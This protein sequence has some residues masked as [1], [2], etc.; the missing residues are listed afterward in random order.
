MVRPRVA[1]MIHW[2]RSRSLPVSLA[3]AAG[4][5]VVLLYWMWRI[6]CRQ[7]PAR[8]DDGEAGRGVALG[9]SRGTV[10][11]SF[12]RG[13]GD[14]PPAGPKLDGQGWEGT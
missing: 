13:P 5:L 1:D 9:L 11:W 12:N 6:R 14:V 10:P 2:R 8:L 7:N 3:L 4:P